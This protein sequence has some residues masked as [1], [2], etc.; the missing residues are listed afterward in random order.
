[1]L[2]KMDRC[3]IVTEEENRERVFLCEG[4]EVKI[5][6]TTERGNILWAVKQKKRGKQS[7]M[8]L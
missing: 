5:L 6:K 1:M 4:K 8:E 2:K 3:L 7:H